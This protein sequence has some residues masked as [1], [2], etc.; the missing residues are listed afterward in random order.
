LRVHNGYIDGKRVSK[1]GYI[2]YSYNPPPPAAIPSKIQPEIKRDI[3]YTT[4]YEKKYRNGKLIEEIIYGN[5][6]IVWLRHV[7]NYKDNQLE[8]LVY[9]SDGKLNQKYVSTLD[10]KDLIIEETIFDVL[11]NKPYGDKKYSYVYEFDKQGNWIK[12]ITSKEI[13]EN[14]KTFFK[15]LYLN[16]RTISYYE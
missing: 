11:P 6:G 2:Q 5:N 9:S 3:R 7:L 1:T 10:K 14:G 13:T 8:F 4:S 15:P 16:Y 12:K